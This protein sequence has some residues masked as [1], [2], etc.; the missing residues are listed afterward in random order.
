[1]QK[2]CLMLIT[3]QSLVQHSTGV[4]LQWLVGLSKVAVSDAPPGTVCSSIMYNSYLLSVYLLRW[5][6]HLCL[7]ASGA[8]PTRPSA[9]KS[10]T[11]TT[12]A[13][14]QSTRPT[15]AITTT[16]AC[17]SQPQVLV[18]TLRAETYMKDGN[19]VQQGIRDEGSERRW[20]N[21]SMRSIKWNRMRYV[22]VK[23]GNTQEHW[24][25][26]CYWISWCRSYWWYKWTEILFHRHESKIRKWSLF[27]LRGNMF[28]HLL[29]HS[30]MRKSLSLSCQYNKYEAIA[31]GC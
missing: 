22:S 19:K 20:M 17:H 14:R 26:K 13:T 16:A 30:Y 18:D 1:M 2:C 21:A 31:S 12:A 4:L 24:N 15:T 11:T 23:D 28:I 10:T 29:T 25:A 5:W 9:R 7:L 6:C 27:L 3:L 8:G